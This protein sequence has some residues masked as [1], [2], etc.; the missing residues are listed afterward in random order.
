MVDDGR[1]EFRSKVRGKM[2]GFLL[3][4]GRGFEVEMGVAGSLYLTGSGE[5]VGNGHLMVPDV[6]R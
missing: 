6:S 2:R 3:V 1:G 5:S 4:L